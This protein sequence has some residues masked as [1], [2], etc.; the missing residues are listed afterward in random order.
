MRL[1]IAIKLPNQIKDQIIAFQDT[2]RGMDGIKWV[3]YENLHLTLKF[4]GTVNEE[5]IEE[6]I[7]KISS[8]IY[9]IKPFHI[10][11]S[12]FGGFPDLRRPRVLWIGI[13]EG[14]PILVKIMNGLGKELSVMGFEA[15]RRDPVP[16]LTIGRARKV[17]PIKLK[18][19][20]QAAC[21]EQDFESPTFLVDTVY[22]IKSDLTTQ[23][24]IYTDIK[25][26]KL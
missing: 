7:Y 13:K 4:L 6:V 22:L 26:L 17:Q 19:P 3:G 2:M 18:I 15:E 14:R 16:H 23:G 25:E 8:A 1:F 12:T 9:G 11:L 20:K 21:K 10:S 5:Q 24:P